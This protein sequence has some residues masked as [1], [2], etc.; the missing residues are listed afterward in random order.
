MYD[1]TITT[2]TNIKDIS[3]LIG[4]ERRKAGPGQQPL[5]RILRQK[6]RIC[7]WGWWKRPSVQSR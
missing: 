3:I 4:I 5:S 7:G 1:N 2:A 6:A